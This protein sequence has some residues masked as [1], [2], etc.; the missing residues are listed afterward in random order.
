MRCPT[1]KPKRIFIQVI[2]KMFSTYRSLMC[3]HLSAC[4]AQAGEPFRRMDF[5]C[6]NGNLFPFTATASFTTY[7]TAAD[8]GLIHLNTAAE[9][10]S[11]KDEPWRASSCA[12]KSMRFDNS[13]IQEHVAIPKH[14]LHLSGLLQTT[15]RQTK[16][17]R[18][19]LCAQRLSPRLPRVGFRTAD[20][21]DIRAQ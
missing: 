11:R 4:D 9:L 6:D 15:S 21:E 14:S 19:S 20:I 7:T 5:N 8:I 2:I 16:F 10:I 17:S 13:P 18:A 1:V 12:T 3:A